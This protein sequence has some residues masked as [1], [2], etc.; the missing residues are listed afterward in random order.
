[1]TNVPHV[2]HDSAIQKGLEEWNDLKSIFA[3]NFPVLISLE[4]KLKEIIHL[5]LPFMEVLYCMADHPNLIVAND[6]LEP[7]HQVLKLK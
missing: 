1:M 3:F 2:A 4:L 6:L 7:S 5:V